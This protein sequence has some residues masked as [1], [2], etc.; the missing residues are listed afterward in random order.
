MLY[1]IFFLEIITSHIRLI[2]KCRLFSIVKEVYATENH[3]CTNSNHYTPWYL[4]SQCTQ[5]WLIVVWFWALMYA[6]N[7]VKSGSVWKKKNQLI[8]SLRINPQ[9]PLHLKSNPLNKLIVDFTFGYFY[10]MVSEGLIQS[11]VVLVVCWFVLI[12]VHKLAFLLAFLASSLMGG[13]YH[14]RDHGAS[15]SWL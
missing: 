14:G 5:Q 4:S 9:T 11:L 7:L 6:S 8:M 3:H 15:R 10:L 2:V 13:V 1:F 12:L